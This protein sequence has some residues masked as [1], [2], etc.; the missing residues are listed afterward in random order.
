MLGQ[1]YRIVAPVGM[2]ASAQVFLADD[3][4]LRRRVAVKMLHEALAGDA[5]FLRRFRAEAHAAAALSHPHVV[6]VFDWGDDEVAFIVTE[7][8]AGGSLRAM[9]DAGT[10]LTTSQA[11]LV[12]LETAR[13]LDYAHRRG[14]VHRDI[15]PANLLFGEEGRLR[16]ADFGLARALAEAA[17]TEPHGAV[18]GTARYASPEQATGSQLTGRADVYSLALV[19]IEAVTG[20]VPFAADTTLGTLMGRVDRPLEVPDALGPLRRVLERAGA[21]DPADRIDAR[22]MA[23]GLLAAARGLSRPDPLPLAGALSRDGFG[24]PDDDPTLH[25]AGEDNG[26]TVEP[27]DARPVVAEMTDLRDDDLDL[28]PPDWV[29]S[30]EPTAPFAT[31]SA[32]AGGDDAEEV[33]DLHWRTAAVPWLPAEEVVAGPLV[34]DQTV[35]YLEDEPGDLDQLDPPGPER[36]T[37][38]PGTAAAPSDGSPDVTAVIERAP[39]IEPVAVAA[40]GI[41]DG[42]S[43]GSGRVGHRRWPWAILVFLV[44]AAAAT[45]TTVALTDRPADRTPPIATF[46]VPD[47]S[48]RSEPAARAAVARFHW[49]VTASHGRRDGTKAGQIIRTDPPAGTRVRQGGRLRLIIS[50]GNTLVAIPTNLAGKPI[51]E[52]RESLVKLGLVPKTTQQVDEKVAKDRVIGLAAGT[53]ARLPRE[54]AVRLVVSDG[55]RPRVVPAGLVGKTE[56]AARLELAAVQLVPNS[57]KEFNELVPAD[58]VIS[59]RPDSGASVARDSGVRL[60]VS[61]GPKPR[62]VPAGLVGVTEATARSRIVGVQLDASTSTTFSESIPAGQVIS[63]EPSSGA[64]LPRGSSVRLKVSSGP[65]PR[66]VPSGLVG[67]A[68]ADARARVVA[69]QLAPSSAKVFSDSVPAGQVISAEPGSGASVPRGSTVTLVVSKG[70]NLVAVPSLKGVKTIDGAIALLRHAG[71]VA[72]NVSGPA[73]G[74]PVSTDPAAGAKV[75]RGSKV[76]IRLG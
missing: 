4:R 55:P 70:P 51:A 14:F 67:L 65:K 56:A 6:A 29:S 69:V 63:A 74:H 42:G 1:R 30:A 11:L 71:L 2:G 38:D 48:R 23:A 15:K 75:R 47:L 31:G 45:A 34:A 50:D 5:D 3:A 58:H 39:P 27:D 21:P 25:G 22:T 72:G 33:L 66:V 46:R 16:V 57:T 28:D 17:W 53:P 9:M 49:K 40:G 24:G 52:A 7:F 13:A 73:T 68:E 36:P 59:V 35:T 64:S 43:S 41:G 37:L 62:V 61:E 32:L 54:Q 20:E 18:L 60:V 10:L 44:L 26:R 19:L 12:G 76:D 8:L